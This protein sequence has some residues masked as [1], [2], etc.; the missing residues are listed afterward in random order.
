MNKKGQIPI[1]PQYFIA[2]IFLAIIVW[3]VHS[4]A[5]DDGYGDGFSEAN[6]SY[7]SC[8]NNL[9]TNAQ[10]YENQLKNKNEELNALSEGYQECLERD[11]RGWYSLH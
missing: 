6:K 2:V 7:T 5:Y 11:P 4:S 1:Q 10:L 9:D 8:L 3:Q